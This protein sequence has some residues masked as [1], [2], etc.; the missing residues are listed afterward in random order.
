M[1][2][3]ESM[4]A[5][6]PMEPMEPMEP[7]IPAVPAVPGKAI[8]E[9]PTEPHPPENPVSLSFYYPKLMHRSQEDVAE[10]NSSNADVIEMALQGYRRLSDRSKVRFLETV[11][12]ILVLL[13]CLMRHDIFS[14]LIIVV[15]VTYGLQTS[16]MIP[17]SCYQIIM[18][19]TSIS[20]LVKYALQLPA[21]GE[22]VNSDGISYIT[23]L[24]AC[25]E[26]GVYNENIFQPLML[27]GIY[28]PGNAGQKGISLMGDIILIILCIIMRSVLKSYGVWRR[29][30]NSYV[31]EEVRFP[32]S[33][34][35]QACDVHDST[36]QESL[37]Q[38]SPYMEANT[39]D[40]ASPFVEEN[41]LCICFLGH[42]FLF[43]AS[44][45]S[46]GGEDPIHHALHVPSKEDVGRAFSCSL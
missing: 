12:S 31:M 26:S 11:Y 27:L 4:E 35:R 39:P 37:Q 28:K 24:S 8:P 14:I 17:H 18:Y 1:E 32:Y 42:S 46:P 5:V 45:E 20:I 6:E 36:D 16:L 25:E 21:F 29:S 2:V 3:V 33:T 22:C 44:Q 34:N 10:E 30:L 23:F 41:G 19:I 15:L 13:L 40:A 9:K 38:L 43:A 7:E